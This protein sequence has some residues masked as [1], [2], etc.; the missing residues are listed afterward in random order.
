MEE[1]R[2]RIRRAT[3]GESLLEKDEVLL[4]TGFITSPADV[5]LVGDPETAK[6]KG[7]GASVEL[8]TLPSILLD[9]LQEYRNRHRGRWSSKLSRLVK[10]LKR[11]K[12]HPNERETEI[13]A[14]NITEGLEAALEL[15]VGRWP[16]EYRRR[17]Y[18][19]LRSLSLQGAPGNGAVKAFRRAK[20]QLTKKLSRGLVKTATR[21]AKKTKRGERTRRKLIYRGRLGEDPGVAE[22]IPAL[23]HPI[24]ILKRVFG[25]GYIT[26]NR[27]EGYFGRKKQF[28]RLH[29]TEKG[30]PSIVELVFLIITKGA[31]TVLDAVR[32]APTGVQGR[33]PR[34]GSPRPPKPPEAGDRCRIEYKDRHGTV[35]T[36]NVRVLKVLRFGSRRREQYI[37][38]F[39]E[40]KGEERTF[41]LDRILS[42]KPIH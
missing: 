6:L 38:A 36:R 42:I 25:N 4:Y 40:L 11:A 15:E 16:K 26:T 37:K 10:S 27:V 24:R 33:R 20:K 12:N 13:V 19:T 23:G 30:N 5:G 17:V 3:P 8:G 18:N 22:R 35:T 39:C 2:V 29:R 34:R 21:S 1:E 9:D 7:L 14:R 31:F 28:L 32:L 41:R